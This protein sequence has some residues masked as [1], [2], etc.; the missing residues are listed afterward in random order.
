MKHIDFEVLIK[1]AGLEVLEVSCEPTPSFAIGLLVPCVTG[2]HIE[3]GSLVYH[4]VE[5]AML[6]TSSAQTQIGALKLRLAKQ[7]YKKLKTL[8]KYWLHRSDYQ[9][10]C[11]PATEDI[12]TDCITCHKQI[13]Q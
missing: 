5:F 6:S 8:R 10:K 4:S 9:H 1:D 7:A 11:T 3:Y 2:M 12:V 13:V